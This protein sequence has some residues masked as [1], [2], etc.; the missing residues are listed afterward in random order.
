MP[1][2]GPGTSAPTASFFEVTGIPGYDTRLTQGGEEVDRPR[3]LRDRRQVVGAADNT[4]A[5]LRRPVA[6]RHGSRRPVAHGA[7]AVTASPRR[8]RVALTATPLYGHVAPLVAVGE[9]LVQRGH[10][11]TLLTGARFADLAARH[12]L[13]FTPLPIE[14]DVAAGPTGPSSRPRVLEG[15][16]AILRT[17]VRPIPAQHAALVEL[18][19]D[20]HWDAVL[21]DA[22]Y[23]GAIPLLLSG[24]PDGRL[25]VLGVS[26]TPLSLVSVDCAP[27][28]SALQPG[29]T[30]WSRMRN[31]HIDCLLRHGPLRPVYDELDAVLA[32]YGVP[33]GTVDYFDHARYFDLTFHL[34]P[35]E[36]EYRRRELPSSV[37]FVGPMK[38][39]AI[40]AP[41]PP[42]WGDLDG[43]CVVLVTQGTLDVDPRKLIAPTVRALADEPVMT[44]VTT[45]GASEGTL[46]DALGGWLPANVR[47]APF[48]PYDDLLPRVR[49]VVSNGGF[50]GVQQALRHGVPL[51]VAGD[52]EDKPEVAAR[53]RRVGAGIDLRTRTPSARQVRRAVRAVLADPG[54]LARAALVS[55]SIDRLGDPSTTIADAVEAA[56]REPVVST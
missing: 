7:Q 21:S 51:V 54:Y 2:G 23:L 39:G 40:A 18:L 31:R 10:E 12:G 38:P 48:L 16:D 56:A 6:H 33:P 4:V 28:G 34:A 19:S 9:A 44:V 25:P 30:G 11:V 5:A 55:R 26:T 41:R 3:R 42:W 47:V 49:A 37:R 50:G 1:D 27:F 29:V 22:A 20:G 15:R 24:P 17:F 8:L 14:A 52:T 53:V 13:G 32:G 45:G 43:R 35:P 36:I 46:T